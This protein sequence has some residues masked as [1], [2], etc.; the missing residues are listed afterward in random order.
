MNHLN[1][2][3]TGSWIVH[4]CWTYNWPLCVNCGP[5]MAPDLEKPQIRHCFALFCKLHVKMLLLL[6]CRHLL[7]LCV[8]SRQSA[9]GDLHRVLEQSRLSN[10]LHVILHL[11]H[12][13]SSFPRTPAPSLNGGRWFL[14]SSLTQSLV[15]CRVQSSLHS[16]LPL[17]FPLSASLREDRA[18]FSMNNRCTAQ[19]LVYINNWPAH[20]WTG[21]GLVNVMM[22]ILQHRDRGGGGA[23][24]TYLADVRGLVTVLNVFNRNSQFS[25]SAKF[26]S[27]SQGFTNIIFTHISSVSLLVSSIVQKL[28]LSMKLCKKVLFE[29]GKNQLD[30]SESPDQV[31]EPGF[32]L[33]FF[34]KCVFQHFCEYL[35]L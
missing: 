30:F 12:R 33:S 19:S 22:M 23:T 27:A 34:N 6:S 17:D 28:Q 31:L 2:H 25:V 24:T 16:H 13:L 15:S 9:E 20:V 3:L 18:T 29:S 35:M 26:T 7:L 1:V 10:Q 21:V 11:S 5:F 4:G 32:F 8:I 14:G